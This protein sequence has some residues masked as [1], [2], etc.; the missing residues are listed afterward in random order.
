MKLVT[1]I[2]FTKIK[3]ESDFGSSALSRALEEL[4]CH[5]FYISNNTKD[6]KTSDKSLCPLTINF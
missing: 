6:I 2:M 1:E 3:T 4:S 5:N